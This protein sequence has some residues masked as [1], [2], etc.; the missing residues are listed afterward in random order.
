MGDINNNN[1]DVLCHKCGTTI[2]FEGNDEYLYYNDENNEEDLF[3]CGP[4][5]KRDGYNI[6][7]EC[8]GLV[9][10]MCRGGGVMD[11]HKMVV[12]HSFEDPGL[13]FNEEVYICRDCAPNNTEIIESFH[14]EEE[15][16][17]ESSDESYESSDESYE[18]SDESE[19]Y[20]DYSE[21]HENPENDG[22]KPLADQ[23]ACLICGSKPENKRTVV[24]YDIPNN[25][26][27]EPC[28]L[29]V[30]N[31]CFCDHCAE[32]VGQCFKCK[33]MVDFRHE[34]SLYLQGFEWENGCVAC[35]HC[36]PPN[37]Q[38]KRSR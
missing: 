31:Y 17:D 26:R 19:Y 24:F 37:D 29:Y 4:C 5:G 28:G 18:S 9:D 7:H 30:R 16:S 11:G 6:C 27:K 1:Y 14:R 21:V 10:T 12:R 38:N 15:R 32:D 13:D 20:D 23:Y 36:S 8:D 33:E 34:R 22:Y 25:K 2:V 3:L 35:L